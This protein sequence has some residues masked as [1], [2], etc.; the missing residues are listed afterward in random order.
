MNGTRL[1]AACGLAAVALG[2]G[3]AGAAMMHPTF[4]AKLSGMGEHGT[5]N[6]QSS[7]TK[8]QLCW[9]F[10]VMTHGV[11]SASIRDGAGMVVAKLGP[12]YKAKSCVAVPK[13]ALEMIET[14]PGSYHVWV[15]TKAHMGELR[16]T[17]TAGMVHS[18]QM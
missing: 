17:L 15:D 12:S 18:S 3:V 4:G 16:G 7:A 13:Q 8:G 5:V 9:T 6:F 10:D 1:F 11:T 2:S 14:K